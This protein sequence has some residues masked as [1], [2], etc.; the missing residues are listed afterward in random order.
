MDE[1]PTGWT[2]HRVRD[3]VLREFSGPSPTCEERNIRE[4][5]EWGLLKTTA[6]VWA[7][8]NPAAHKVPPSSYW[9]RP[10]IEVQ[11]GDVLVTKAGPR[12]R[13]GVVVDVFQT[14]PRL[15]VSGK[16]VGLRP[17]Q[18]VVVP[19]I[20]AGAIA[21]RRSQTYLDQRTTGMAESQVNFSNASLLSTPLHLPPL[22]E[23]RRVA[24]I[25]DMVDLAI[26][27]AEG[28]IAKL[29][30]L[31]TGFLYDVMS[32]LS[33]KESALSDLLVEDF[34]GAWGSPPRGGPTDVRVLR[35]TEICDDGQLRAGSAVSRSLSATDHA[36]RLLQ[37]G[38]I[39]LEASGGAPGRPVGRTALFAEPDDAG[40]STASNFVRVLR[41][42]ADAD[43]EFLA[44]YLLWLYRGPRILRFQQQTTGISNL[45]V[46]E[47]LAQRIALPELGEQVSVRK[48]LT[49][50]RKRLEA[51]RAD[52][53]KL[54]WLKQ[55]LMDDLLTGR[56]RVNLSPDDRESE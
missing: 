36:K 34:A 1:L 26:R 15:M 30:A 7:G 24:E 47:Y 45:R 56:V 55:G 20:L 38:D 3:L 39:L 42:K 49:S 21:S 31:N 16:M 5:S 9:D 46:R 23:Q 51:E 35:S 37:S 8:W 41:I 48:R 40:K 10:D 54:R 29:G 18:R 13:V 52:L 14:P 2:A 27:S 25:L 22:P 19:R 11:E 33:G 4:S 53:A 6:I 50:M 32:T 43:S 17:D 44:W 12:H 28:L